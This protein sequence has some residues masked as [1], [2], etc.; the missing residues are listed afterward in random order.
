MEVTLSKRAWHV[1]L[2]KFV[3]GKQPPFF[4]LCPYFWLTIFN[5]LV[6]MIPVAI[7]KWIVIPL[8]NLLGNFYDDIIIY[9]IEQST[10]S[11]DFQKMYKVIIGQGYTLINWKDQ[12]SIL[13][14]KLYQ[15]YN[16]KE[17]DKYKWL[18][19]YKRKLYSFQNKIEDETYLREKKRKQNISK[20]LD[21]F[22]DPLKSALESAKD[23]IKSIK[24]SQIA[25]WT[26]R[27][28]NVIITA[29]LSSITI[30]VILKIYH[31]IYM[32]NF[33]TLFAISSVICCIVLILLCL[34]LFIFIIYLLVENVFDTDR[35]KNAIN[36]F[37]HYLSLFFL[38]IFSWIWFPFGSMFSFFITYFKA[39][40][41]DYC[42]A[43]N[44]KE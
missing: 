38:K 30:K 10:V 14:N 11:E 16:V 2:Y 3:W 44:W 28:F 29:V 21:S 5:M 13:L 43:I 32:G 12:E 6:A 36:S 39:T 9:K 4:S 26:Q 23:N 42:P 7:F 31:Y 20:V 15:K 24:Q 33:A 37:W 17:E 8:S 22:F 25:V 1:K 19:D 34:I 18:H 40:K 27:F 35:F 41:N